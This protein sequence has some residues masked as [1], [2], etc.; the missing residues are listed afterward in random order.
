VSRA[1]AL[2]SLLH[3]V[4]V[5]RAAIAFALALPAGLAL[6]AAG[7]RLL[8]VPAAG[9]LV[10]ALLAVAVAAGVARR[11]FLAIDAVWLN[12]QLDG[13]RPE[14]ED[15]TAL[16]W[17]A[18][19]ALQGLTRLQRDR[20]A[21]R[22]DAAPLPDLRSPWPWRRLALVWLVALAIGVLA[23]AVP[24]RLDQAAGSVLSGTST[25]P[26][27]PSAL[28]VTHAQLEVQPPAYTGLPAIDAVGLEATV[29]EGATVRWRIALN[30]SPEAVR[31]EFLDGVDLPLVLQDGH[32]QGERSIDAAV[33]YRLVSEGGPTL[34]EADAGLNR[35]EIVPDS[36]PALRV[37]SPDRTLTLAESGQR[38]WLLEFEASDDYGLASA[39]LS[40]TLAHGTGENV[41]FSET[42][43]TL[44]GEGE[45]TRKRYRHRIALAEAGFE[46][47][48]DLILRLSVA[49]NRLPL[50]NITRHPS[51]ILR[52]PLAQGGEAG[53]LEGVVRDVMPAYF[54]S[55]RQIII[56]TEA[57][58][59]E[60]SALDAE[61][62]AQR[63]DAIGVDQRILRLRYGQFL[64]EETEVA[65]PPP[66][67][68]EDEHSEHSQ[69]DGHDHGDP[70]PSRTARFGE[71]DDV[72]SEY[73]H[74]H[75]Y[76]EAATLFDSKTKELLR[77][78]L[79]AM[80]QAE[81]HLRTGRPAEALPHE[82]RALDF[83]KRVQQASRIYLARVGLELSPVDFGR[84]L[85]GDLAGVGARRDPLSARQEALDWLVELWTALERGEPA[86]LDAL[87]RWLGQRPASVADPLSLVAALDRL[88]RDPDC[89]NCADSLARL[90]WPL[91]P[92]PPAQVSARMQPDA[93]GERYLDALQAESAD[94]G[95]AQ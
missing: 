35:I 5:R 17:L 95:G 43:R 61:T 90:I 86:D 20:I 26:V 25:G 76:A 92:R 57:L 42:V 81:L 87:D 1:D 66:K 80:W 45:A 78:A 50:A 29:P 30:A 91:L 60:R 88:R 14:F 39:R 44:H 47:G 65:T 49:D 33:L 15:S 63:S 6:V 19:D 68:G 13:L 69:G 7:W 56:D 79:N 75:D 59:A 54:R 31:L 3:R 85:G 32:W 41:V 24:A 16:L 71:I 89:R 74:T 77:S 36:A 58:L 11:A 12:R 2:R 27:L 22:V 64:G 21:A 8:M 51:L 53:T 84:R 93:A 72:L 40:I 23:L 34:A 82:Y 9:A 28:E 4:R 48:D 37:F 55:Q 67:T 94:R 52:W 10:G 46:P 73:G 62:F 38:D 83:I 70:E 18:P